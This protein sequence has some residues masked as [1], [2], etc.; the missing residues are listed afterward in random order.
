VLADDVSNLRSQIINGG[1]FI[2][3][4]ITLFINNSG[5]F[6][7]Q[8]RARRKR[9]SSKKGKRERVDEEEFL[10]KIIYGNK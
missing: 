1:G 6:G 8:E 4:F 7:G 9:S 2:T 3:K 5:I 10:N